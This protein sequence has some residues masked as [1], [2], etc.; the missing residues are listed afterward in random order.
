MAVLHRGRM[1]LFGGMSQLLVDVSTKGTAVGR[2]DGRA[3]LDVLS[4]VG[5][6]GM[7]WTIVRFWAWLIGQ[8]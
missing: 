6:D 3:G 7:C 1:V 5:N 4:T 2:Q 8:G